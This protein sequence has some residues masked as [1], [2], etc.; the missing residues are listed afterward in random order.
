M[1]SI[2]FS[3]Q[4]DIF[5]NIKWFHQFIHSCGLVHIP[6]PREKQ[7]SNNNYH[8]FSVSLFVRLFVLLGLELRAHPF[9]HCTS[10][11]C[12]MEIMK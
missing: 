1:F 6:S 10:P 4:S 11:I 9:S 12:V 7:Y 2:S 3:L 8:F 5:I